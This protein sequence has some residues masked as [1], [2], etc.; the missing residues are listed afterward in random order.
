MGSNPTFPTICRR[1]YADVA[2]LA[3]ALALGASGLY[4]G[5]SSPSIRTIN[6]SHNT[7]RVAR[8]LCSGLWHGHKKELNERMVYALNPNEESGLGL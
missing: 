8:V 1:I 2:E 4:R 5:G 3:D 6:H 7:T